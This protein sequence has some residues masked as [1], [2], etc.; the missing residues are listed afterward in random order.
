MGE[1]G[2]PD[3]NWHHQVI[4]G[5]LEAVARGEIRNLIDNQPPR[6]T[7]TSLVS[8]CFQAWIWCQPP[9]R[10]APLMGPHVKFLCV[11]YGAKLAEE[12][13]V[14]ARRLIQG[15]WYQSHW[16]HQ[17][18]IRDDQSNR[19]NF[20][21]MLGGERLS[22]SIEGGL[23]G[24][25]GDIQIVDDPHNL[26]GA[27]SDIQRRATIDA[28]RSLV[29]RVTDPRRSARILVMQRL[30]LDDATNYA[31]E[32]WGVVKHL[33]FPMRYEVRRAVPE[34]P[35]TEE[36]ELLWPEVWN[37]EIVEQEEKELTEYGVA[38]QLQ[39]SPTTKGGEIIKRAMWRLWPGDFPE[40]DLV[41]AI[42]QCTMCGWHG[43]KPD[44]DD[45]TIECPSC[46]SVANRHIAFPEFS[47][48]L[49]SVDT[50][51]GEKQDNSWSAATC[52]GVWHDK[53]DAPRA[54]LMHAW[55]GRPRLRGMPESK[56]PKEKKGLVETIHEIASTRQVD[57]ILIEHKTRGTDL[58]QEL[59]RQMAEWPYNLVY[60]EPAGSKE[61]R[62][63]ACVP[64]F[65]NDR[66]WAPDKIWADQVISEV[67][68]QPRA[69][70]SDLSDTM[71]SA[72]I[73][74]RRQGILSLGD[75]Y[76]REQRRSLLFKGRTDRSTVREMYEGT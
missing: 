65:T 6:T 36:G 28:M 33:M 49:L 72:L 12:I 27:E 43:R 30:H 66:V 19:N 20:A 61:I 46:D 64:L 54:M 62:L 5:H 74:M 68:A 34:D 73:W 23:L 71:S 8:I 59:E 18:E 1:P 47:Y 50:A 21:N 37:E 4:A 38:G 17:V 70:F 76:R 39:Q 44:T 9:E 40:A 53:E 56:N 67:A 15:Y 22:S 16:G 75:E 29:T 63:E 48:R 3:I 60:F 14:K 35:R 55:R 7:K 45:E 11:S 51:Y 10:W 26:E 52:W 25:G 24:R 41:D 42:Y 13:A 31:L 57:T 69:Q 2:D 32:N 58:Y